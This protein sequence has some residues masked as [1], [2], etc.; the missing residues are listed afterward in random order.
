MIVITPSSF[1][2]PINTFSEGGA[3]VAGCVVVGGAVVTGGTVVA[4]GAVVTGCEEF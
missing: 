3:V 1:A 2:S 4:G